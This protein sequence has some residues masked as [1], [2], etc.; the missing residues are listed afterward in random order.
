[1]KT[2]QTEA[3]TMKT[4]TKLLSIFTLFTLAACA[5]SGGGLTRT[6]CEA[7]VHDVRPGGR[8][9]CIDHDELAD[10]FEMEEL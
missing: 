3:N 7:T 6:D 1:M 5:T 2:P 8:V 4:L 10:A 9:E